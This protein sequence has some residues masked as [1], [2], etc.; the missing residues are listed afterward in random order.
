M[1]ELAF[2]RVKDKGQHTGE[3]FLSAPES[4]H[5]VATGLTGEQK[6]VIKIPADSMEWLAMN[7][8]MA[9]SHDQREFILMGVEEAV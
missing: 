4:H 5:D 8:L 9:L 1:S 6:H 3:F 2:G 7:A